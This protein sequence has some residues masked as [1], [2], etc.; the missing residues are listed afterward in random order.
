MYS[1]NIRTSVTR[2][3]RMRREIHDNATLV[4]QCT[5]IVN[6]NPRNLERLRIARKPQGYHL[7]VPGHS[8]WH[9]LFVT[10]KPR[11]IVAEVHHFKNGPVIT[12]SSNEWALKKQ[13]YRGT[14]GSAYINVARLLALRCLEAGI[15]E[16]EVN[17]DLKGEKCEL[18]LKE[19]E[20]G[21]II[22][23]EPLVYKYPNS[24]DRYRP[25]KP[26]EIHE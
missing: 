1:A 6:R 10:K 26:W 2:A 9:K 14:D 11:Y 20:N 22:L 23:T 7:E 4:E 25:E 15:C 8:Y 12:V 19:L 16:M 3:F 21:G 24:W 18:L 17:S 13:L 5:E